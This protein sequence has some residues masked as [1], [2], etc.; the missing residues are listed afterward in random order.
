[1]HASADSLFLLTGKTILVAGGTRGIGKAIS[2]RLARAGANVIANYVRNESA[3]QQLK[4]SACEEGLRI[5]LCRAD[6]T[7]ER[8]LE[9]IRHSLQEHTPDLSGLV[10]CAATGVHGP[11]QGLTARHFDWTLDLNVRAFF[12]L[13]QLLTDYLSEGSTVVALSSWGAVRALPNYAL[14]GAS[15]GAL[16]ALTRHLARELAQRGIRVN[17]VTA[18][19]VL[20]D[21]WRAVPGADAQI[22][23]IISRTPTGRLVTDEQVAYGVQFLCSDAAAGVIGHTLVVDGG[24]GIVA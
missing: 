8:G 2:L 20:T 15:K 3:A 11:L 24:F 6:L 10:Y 19:A 21:A 12:R 14:V 16:D 5:T 18:G 4:S 1:M 22:N 9:Q 17:I 23:E 7:T 13:I